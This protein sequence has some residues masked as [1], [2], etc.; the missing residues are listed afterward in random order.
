MNIR[1]LIKVNIVN[2]AILGLVVLFYFLTGLLF[3]DHDSTASLH[4]LTN[5]ISVVFFVAW[6]AFTIYS[7]VS[8]IKEDKLE[9]KREIL[10]I[11][12]RLMR[13]GRKNFYI[14]ERKILI[15]ILDSLQSREKYIYMMEDDSKVRELFF[16]TENQI[17][18]NAANVCEYMETFD[19][20]NGRDS[21]YVGKICQDSQHL[22]D[23]FNK[24]MELSVT[25]DDTAL[26]YD[27]REIDD[28]INALETM[29]EAGKGALRS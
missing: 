11:R 2:L 17:L 18:R 12:N 10:E 6:A 1:K 8:V 7:N 26:D 14:N 24:L 16:L 19:Y 22:L 3:N 23:R 25:Y 21:G 4:L 15:S 9:K 13:A 29:R 5:I 20:I 27:T 28:M